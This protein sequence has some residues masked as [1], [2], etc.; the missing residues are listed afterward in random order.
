MGPDPEV[1]DFVQHSYS[2]LGHQGEDPPALT[3]EQLAQVEPICQEIEKV[4][5]D[6]SLHTWD[7]ILDYLAKHVTL[8]SGLF[9][10]GTTYAS[11]LL[12]KCGVRTGHEQIFSADS[13][14]YMKSMVATQMDVEISGG[15]PPW[16]AAL[17][18]RE[19]DPRIRYLTLVRH[20]VSLAN[21]RIHFGDANGKMS[22]EDTLGVQRDILTQFELNMLTMIP[23]Y[24]WRVESLSDQMDVLRLFGKGSIKPEKLTNARGVDRNSKF[25]KQPAV[26]SWDNLIR[27]LKDWAHDLGYSEKGGL[28]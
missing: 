8:I 14:F 27:P 28:R 19:P 9:K 23:E 17:K 3:D 22:S 15:M 16:I 5:K 2:I 11:R 6:K 20:P 26:V 10:G 24:I 21:S 18:R 7:N 4:M 12:N 1:R 25:A 13:K